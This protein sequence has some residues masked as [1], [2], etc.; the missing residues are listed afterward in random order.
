VARA[1]EGECQD[2]LSRLAI[3]FQTVSPPVTYDNQISL[4]TN[5]MSTIGEGRGY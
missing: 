5:G 3:D 2:G 1:T 4:A